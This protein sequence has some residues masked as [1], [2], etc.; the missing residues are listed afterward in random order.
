MNLE[1]SCLQSLDIAGL[2]TEMK[3][4]NVDEK[5]IKNIVDANG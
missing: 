1:A 2:F 4:I 5:D 3:F